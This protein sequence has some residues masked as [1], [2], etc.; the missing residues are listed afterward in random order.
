MYKRQEDI[1][2]GTNTSDSPIADIIKRFDEAQ[3]ACADYNPTSVSQKIM[4]HESKAT[5]YKDTPELPLIL[6]D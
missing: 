5:L 3:H 6:L 2:I 4:S 1:L